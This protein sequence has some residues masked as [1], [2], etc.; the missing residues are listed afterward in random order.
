MF[1]MGGCL[2]FIQKERSEYQI[3][4]NNR[5]KRKRWKGKKPRKKSD[6]ILPRRRR[7]IQKYTDSKEL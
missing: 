6:F 3:V 5:K 1:P 7:L 2:T 4:R